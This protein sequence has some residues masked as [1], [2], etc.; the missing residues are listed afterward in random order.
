MLILNDI[1]KVS[2]YHLA[3]MYLQIIH[4]DSNVEYSGHYEKF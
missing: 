1:G 2:E 4:T 3:M